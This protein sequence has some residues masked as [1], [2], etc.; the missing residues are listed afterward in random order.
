VV[1]AAV[2]GDLTA[3][4]HTVADSQISDAAASTCTALVSRLSGSGA[5]NASSGSVTV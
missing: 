2:P 4:A 1:A 5:S 3:A